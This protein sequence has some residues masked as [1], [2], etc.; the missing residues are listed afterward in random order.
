MLGALATRTG[1]TV[2]GRYRN[3]QGEYRVLQTNARPRFSSAGELLGM[4]GVNVDITEQEAAQHRT[5]AD[6]SAMTRLQELGT[7]CAREGQ[8]QEKCFSA[9]VDAAIAIT[10]APRGSLQ[11]LDPRSGALKIVAQHGH[12]DLFLKFFA[13]VQYNAPITAAAAMRA[14][15]RIVVEDVTKGVIYDQRMVE[16]LVDAGVRAVQATPLI[17]AEG[18]VFGVIATHFAEP[19]RPQDSELRFVDLLAR[20]AADYLSR[21]A[22]ED[23]L[24]NLQSRLKAEVETRTRERD[25]IGTSRRTCSEYRI[26]RAIS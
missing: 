4:I 24:R 14:K 17:D 12:G 26:S 22:A 2:S 5:F 1:V 10:G 16:V 19:H 9:I 18:Q 13:S 8:K 3:S 25:R 11:L 7:L 23:A 21:I 15:N 20:Q 6:L